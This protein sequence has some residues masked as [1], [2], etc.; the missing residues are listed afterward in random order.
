MKINRITTI[1]LSA[2]L[3][4]LP[5]IGMAKDKTP[6]AIQWDDNS[7]AVYDL[8]VAEL[9]NADA[10]YAS[11]ADTLV[12]FAKKQK[13]D[14]LFAKAFRTLLQTERYG[15]AVDLM[16]TWKKN[17]KLPIDELYVLSL[18]LDKQTDKA[19]SVIKD[20]ITTD[21]DD[22]TDTDDTDSHN[23][24]LIGYI[25]IL[26]EN[27]YHPETLTVIEK[28]Y[29]TYPDNDMVGRAYAQLTSYYGKIDKAIKVIDKHIF[30]TPT[31]VGFLQ[32]KSDIYR[33][34]LRLKDAEKV[35]T[36]SLNDYPKNN[37]IRLAYAQFL[38]DKYDFQAAEK[39]LQ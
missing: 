36:D 24:K 17:T 35:W 32:V 33:Y 20:N 16:T 38:Y 30:K 23:D 12:K 8:L 21:S 14:R 22:N 31:D 9:Q 26:M 4:C 18:V 15:D 19:L 37:D 3:F 39:Q 27:W 29:D 6:T 28:L 11:S 25:Q 13:D 10:D 7:Q 1:L 34:D 2:G 5:A